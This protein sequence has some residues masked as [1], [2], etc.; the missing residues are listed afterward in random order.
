MN[1]YN[2]VFIEQVSTNWILDVLGEDLCVGL[3]NLGYICR[4]GKYEDYNGEDISFHMWWALTQP[5]KE[6]KLNAIF[7]TH[8]D[9]KFKEERLI[10]IKNDY[11]VFFC[12]STEDEQ[13]LIELGFE[14]SKVFG[15]NLPVR[16]SYVRPIQIGIFSRCYPDK[17]KNEEWLF[18]YCRTH[19]L[20]KLVDFVFI[21]DGW[22]EFVLRLSDLDCSFQ[23]HNVSRC[24]PYEYMY[25]QLKLANLDYYIYMGMDG[26]A[27][28]SYDAYAMGVSLCI[29]DDGFHK[30]I[31]NIDYSF[32]SEQ[33]FYHCL[34]CIIEKQN[35]KIVFFAN[36]TVDN[37]VKK[38]AYVLENKK[39]PAQTTQVTFN[40]PIKDKRRSFYFKRGTIAAI[41]NN[42]AVIFYNWI[43]RLKYR[44]KQQTQ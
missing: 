31:P 25:Q 12:M 21:G 32:A 42:A 44:Q 39:H 7:I 6:A 3:Q 36:N 18:N 8:T 4:C 11:D 13:F 28:G 35:N 34:D 22:N 10:K 33:E 30:G 2:S 20:C 40:Q 1:K 5:H 26:G 43:N 27:M 15:I 37:Y 9:D 17:R 19:P 29:T 24:M 38:V 14:K 23:W 16:N 41:R